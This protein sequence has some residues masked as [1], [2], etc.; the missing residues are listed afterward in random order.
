MLAMLV[1]WLVVRKMIRIARSYRITS[2]ADF[3]GS[4]YGKSRL[5][6]A[7]VTLITVVG[8]VPYIALQLKAISAGYA[9]MT[10]PLGAPDAEGSPGADDRPVTV[11]VSPKG[12]QA[13]AGVPVRVTAA[14]GRLTSVTVT[15]AENHRLTGKVAAD[16]RSWVSDRK[17]VPGAAYTV[18]AATRTEGGTADSTRAALSSPATPAAAST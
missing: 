12:E 17:A 15:D 2:I 3:I 7:L 5:L 13:P 6:A 16:G 4:R 10:S 8:I 11:T 14:G 9:L 1:A 18:T